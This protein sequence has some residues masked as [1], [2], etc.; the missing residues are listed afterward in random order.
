MQ[1]A[2]LKQ[3]YA[4]RS[5]DLKKAKEREVK[6]LKEEYDR[7]RKVL[8]DKLKKAEAE[9]TQTLEAIERENH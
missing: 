5:D 6:K 3:D 8:E 2:S 9:H 7:S 4:L 1:V